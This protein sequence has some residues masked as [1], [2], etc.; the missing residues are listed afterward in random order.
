ML[1]CC[2]YVKQQFRRKRLSKKS[3][4]RQNLCSPQSMKPKE[5]IISKPSECTPSVQVHPFTPDFSVLSLSKPKRKR[6]KKDAFAVW[7]SD[8]TFAPSSS[9]SKR[10]RARK[11]K[12]SKVL[13]RTKKIE[14]HGTLWNAWVTADILFS[15][16]PMV[17]CIDNVVLVSMAIMHGMMNA[18]HIQTLIIEISCDT[19]YSLCYFKLLPIIYQNGVYSQFFF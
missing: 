1:K 7:F 16:K 9:S 8:V 15:Q 14:L 19:L 4:P 10:T 12:K 6:R 3:K 2:P 18:K 13:S 5:T 11:R 17:C